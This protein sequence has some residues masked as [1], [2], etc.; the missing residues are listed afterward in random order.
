MIVV[1]LTNHLPKLVGVLFSCA[2]TVLKEDDKQE[3]SPCGQKYGSGG[4][5]CNL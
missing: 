5:Q 4:H 1:D 3:E 2:S